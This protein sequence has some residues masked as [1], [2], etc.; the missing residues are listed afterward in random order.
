MKFTKY[1]GKPISQ[2]EY[3]KIIGSLMYAMTCTRPD[4]AFAVGKLSRF[5]SNPGPQHCGEPP[6]L[7]GYPDASWITN[8]E[9][10]SSTSGCVFFY[11]GGAISW[12]SKKQMV[13]ADSN[14]SA[15]HCTRLGEK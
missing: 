4:I 6:I 14:M 2:L 8:E 13:I 7:E 3:A 5:T 9:D 15:I 1:T 11:G 12:A 10:I